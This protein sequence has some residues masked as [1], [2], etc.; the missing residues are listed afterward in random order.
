[1]TKPLSWD[2][3]L[4]QIKLFGATGTMPDVISTYTVNSDITRFYGWIDQGLLRDIPDEM[5][6]KYP[7]LKGIFEQST[8]L[9]AVKQLKDGKN[10]FIPRPESVKDYYK[11][12]HNVFYYRKDWMANVGI[13]EPPKT[14]DGLYEMLKAF[15]FNDPDK[16][17]KND[18]Y[19][20]TMANLNTIPFAIW[21]IDPGFWVEED[22]KW[23]PGYFSE[24]NIEPL[25]YFRKLYQEGLLDPEFSKNGWKQAIQKLTTNT[26]GVLLRNGDLHWINKTIR[27]NWGVANPEYENP[28][29]IVGILPPLA[30]DESSQPQWPIFLSTGG[31]EISSQVDDEK[32][33]R[34][35]ELYEYLLRPD[36][37][38]M[39][40]YGIEGV[41]Y[42]KD[43]DKII[44]EIDPETGEPVMSEWVRS[45]FNPLAMN[46]N[47]AISYVSTP[48]KDI[49]NIQWND[50]FTQIV[51][52][53]ED[54][55]AMFN[56]FIEDSMNQGMATAIE[57]LN[58]KVK[59][60][61]PVP[62]QGYGSFKVYPSL[63]YT[64][65]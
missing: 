26:F 32:L 48:A 47:I 50:A 58:A 7:T 46:V 64:R 51:I 11:A 36:V 3:D 22:G 16:N 59:E 62:F 41:D 56:K 55:E 25:K 53:T 14:V 9:Q 30:K 40:A 10:W 27:D 1:M 65:V 18:T 42:K 2:N 19:G 31:S 54:V 28:F 57:E 24:K 43:G 29:D 20:L 17:G 13:S 34:I 12:S 15:T 33:D 49:T 60:L 45:Q 44:R 52:G 6:A 38:E 5:V 23:I 61:G 21:G 63:R 35:L 8:V 37:R 39:L 4:E